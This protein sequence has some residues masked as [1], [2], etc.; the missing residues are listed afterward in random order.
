MKKKDDTGGHKK[1]PQLTPQC[2]FDPKSLGIS[3]SVKS[4]NLPREPSRRSRTQL[5]YSV[6]AN[7][8][9]GPNACFKQELI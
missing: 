7:Y 5:K 8:A 9:I 3:L 1:P 4:T 2:P 6:L